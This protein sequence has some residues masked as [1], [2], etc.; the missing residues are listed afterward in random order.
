M[1]VSLI[2]LLLLLGIAYFQATQGLFS[3]LIMSVLTVCCAAIAFGFY[4]WIA[5]N[6]LAV[7]WKPDFAHA[8]ALG[9]LFGVPLVL[10]R[11]AFDKLIRRD[12]LL[13][14]SIDRVG[15]GVCG[16][17]SGFVMTGVMAL[18]VQMLPFGESIIGFARFDAEA[19]ASKS[20]G[21]RKPPSASAKE[22]E[23]WLSPDRFASRLAGVLSEGVFSGTQKFGELHPNLPQAIGWVNTTKRDIR[24][25]AP[26]GSMAVVSTEPVA[27]VFRI[28][29]APEAKRGAP[30]QL[31]EYEEL[32]AD[33]DRMLQMVRVD[34]KAP[35]LDPQRK[36]HEFT[37]RQFRLVGKLDGKGPT[38]QAYPVA[39]QQADATEIVN[40]HVRFRKDPRGDWPVTQEVFVPRDGNQVE[41]VFDLPKR[42]VPNFLEYKKNAR[43]S[44]KFLSEE[45]AKAAA[46]AKPAPPKVPP[47][48][49]AP[50]AGSPS[51]GSPPAAA[52]SAAP[53][54]GQERGGR[55]RGASTGGAENSGGSGSGSAPSEPVKP[56]DPVPPSNPGEAPKPEAGSAAKT[57][58]KPAGEKTTD[59]VRRATAQSGAAT[60]GDDL[61]VVMRAYRGQKDFQASNGKLSN[62]HL[63]GEVD[64]Q[65][66][67]GDQPI[68]KF[69]VPSDKR[70]LRLGVTALQARS[71]L[72]RAIS[73]AT[74]TVQ[75][76]VVE[77]SQG[78]QTLL[79]GK[80]A[81]A[82]V[83]SQQVIEI[84]YFPEHEGTSIGG[85]GKF[86]R[87]PEDKLTKDDDLVFLFLVDPGAQIVSF[88]TGTS[89]NR[90]DDLVSENIIAPN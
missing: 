3:A 57:E 77:D 60:F 71:G 55:R 6:L 12:C 42:F 44:V 10:L 65:E 52:P 62:G 16:L 84:Q 24:H 47:P 81:V 58:S 34:L 68:S 15:A 85:L 76:Y 23:L 9:A 50:G 43:A 75:N 29:P 49:P 80:Y 54:A 73:F 31:A 26:P 67:G 20:G 51:T 25:Y 2:F 27:S 19:T 41:V 69:E 17:I 18:S 56:A 82:N 11:L 21:D 83:G 87:I 37:L 13:P 36:S 46:E 70:L 30:K 79:C 1:V 63:V 66:K 28:M 86:A 40:R 61:P 22:D 33:A 89:A 7:Y 88:S 32:P 48:P 39:I 35:A 45:Q 78:R 74:G 8:I 38:L 5:V 90:K 72:G 14:L 4:E 64:A 59:R 53:S